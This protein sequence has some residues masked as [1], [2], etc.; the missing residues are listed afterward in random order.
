MPSHPLLPQFTLSPPY[1]PLTPLHHTGNS[2]VMIS[3]G[4]GIFKVRPAISLISK[5]RMMDT[6]I[7]L[8]FISLSQPPLHF[9]PL[10]LFDGKEF[11]IGDFYVVPQ[12]IN[13]CYVDCH[14]DSSATVE[15]AINIMS[16]DNNHN[17]NNNNNSSSNA[18]THTTQALHLPPK[19]GLAQGPGLEAQG[20]GL[21]LRPGS[22][23]DIHGLAST[24][25]DPMLR[26]H[27][28]TG[29]WRK[30]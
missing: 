12:W 10:F 25:G 22:P 16:A 4:V 6:G 30:G 7:G 5:Q 29:K 26:G 23:A 27:R 1:Y 20:P 18:T 11:D 24:T 15:N 14:K 9:V 2:I 8:D 21:V 3:A 19:H 28:W 13:V 17:H